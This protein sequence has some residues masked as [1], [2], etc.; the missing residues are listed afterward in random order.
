MYSIANFFSNND[1]LAV[2][3]EDGEVYIW[4]TN[5]FTLSKKYAIHSSS[6]TTINYSPDGLKLALGS[7]N[8]ILQIIYVETGLPVFTKTM[9]SAI[10][11]L[12]WDG[13][14]L[15]LGCED[16]SLYIWDMVEVRLLHEINKA[17]SGT[18]FY[19]FSYLFIA[20]YI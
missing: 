14:L 4:K 1:H 10:F 11:S 16:G 9:K 5:D 15:I 12:K 18:S 20:K 6:I 7:K 8:K 3:T 2:G 13:F 19:Y 17:H